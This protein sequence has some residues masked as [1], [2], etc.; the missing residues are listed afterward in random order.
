MVPRLE[1]PGWRAEFGVVA[2][3]T[4]RGEAK[5]PFDLGLASDQPVGEVLARWAAFRSAEPG[6]PLAAL[7]RQ[8]HGT[9]IAWHEGGQGWLILDGID[10]HGTSAPG[11]LMTV[12]VADCT[13]VYLL[14]P[15]QGAMVLL[16]AGWRG[17][18]SKVLDRG[19]RLMKGRAGTQVE[20]IVMH[21]GVGICGPCYEVGPEVFSA[22]GLPVP[23]GGKGLLDVREQLAQQGRD[24]GIGRISVSSWCSG[25]D[26]ALFHSHRRSNGR[27]GRM[28]AY[29][30][31]PLATPCG[32]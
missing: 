9:E 26:D 4:T 15:V 23:A 7:G 8:V 12:T 11:V 1:I 3:V 32:D 22:F 14:D 30:G 16:H 17:A 28:I 25:H 2:G 27:D 31:R 21:C 19:I 5:A 10:G 6:F 18:S 24:L 13:P 29:L 20:N